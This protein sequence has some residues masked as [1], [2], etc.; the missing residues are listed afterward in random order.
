MN[1][2]ARTIKHMQSE[3]AELR[4]AVT[5]IAE[6]Q[7]AMTALLAELSGKAPAK[8]Q[9]AGRKAKATKKPKASKKVVVLSRASREAFIEASALEGWDFSGLSVLEIA[10]QCVTETESWAPLGFTIGEGYTNRVLFG[11]WV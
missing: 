5:A 11:E 4:S 8:N 9:P 3:Y 1:N 6:G 2:T 7:V 10:Q